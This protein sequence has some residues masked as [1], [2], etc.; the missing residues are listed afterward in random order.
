LFCA[1]AGLGAA[2][3]LT[4]ALADTASA[5]ILPSTGS[6]TASSSQ[7]APLVG[8]GTADA[9]PGQYIVVLKTGTALR[10]AG[11]STPSGASAAGASVVAQ[12]ARR[13]NAA[14]GRVTRQYSHA[15]S[16]YSAR[17]SASAL[18]AVRSDPAVAYVQ[19]NH[20]IRAAATTSQ[21]NGVGAVQTRADWGLSR[22][23]QRT[24]STTSSYYYQN[25]GAGVRAYVVDT[26]IRSTSEDFTTDVDG[27]PTS[28]RVSGGVCDIPVGDEDD[29]TVGCDSRGTEGCFT[30]S[31][32]AG[33]GT[34]V[35]GTIGG[36]VYGVAK[37]VTLVPVRVLGCD[38]SSTEDAVAA[39]LDW[40]V[41]DHES[42]GTPAVANLSLAGAA[43]DDDTVVDD[44]VQRVI[45]AGVTV[46]VAAGNGVYDDSTDEYGGVSAC[47]FSPADVADAITVGATDKNDARA[48]FS[49][50]GSCVDVYAPGVNITSDWNTSDTA[51]EVL[52]GTSMATPHVAGVAALYLAA[53]PTATPAQVQ[54]A[55]VKASTANVVT[56]VS[57]SWPRRMLFSLQALK[58]PSATVSATGIS[59]GRALL[60]GH[61]LVSPNKKYSLAQ[62]T[63]G[64]QFRKGRTVLWTNKVAAGWTQ[65]Q[66]DGDLVSSDAYGRVK[67]ASGTTGGAATLKV[68]SNGTATIVDADTKAVTWQVPK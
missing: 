53:H 20:V 18:T 46:V 30:D 44:A 47:E 24:R 3:L 63:A 62:T 25:T 27:T 33:H 29:P 16:G 17:L 58:A 21:A 48:S 34:H 54:S 51:T 15:F 8:A 52:D 43:E 39:G 1:L 19:A 26:G 41:S 13:A 64:L 6:A 49:N 23:D 11:V 7:L 59:S 56:N 42:S 32:D 65:L 60:S 31:D 38:G 68:N 5:A 50:Y 12:H 45:D 4:P 14:G 67:W 55:L 35:A 22:I 37:Q 2:A 10:A 36:T 40:V 66:A 61:A 28:S 9:I 57:K